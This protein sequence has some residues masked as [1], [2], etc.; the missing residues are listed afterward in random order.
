ML[1]E[2]CYRALLSI[3]VVE[4]TNGR[5]AREACLH[6]HAPARAAA[7]AGSRAAHRARSSIFRFQPQDSLAGGAPARWFVITA[8]CSLYSLFSWERSG[9]GAETK[10]RI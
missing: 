1:Y 2:V 10:Q 6:T 8:R 3:S 4:A 9:E 7:R 5:V